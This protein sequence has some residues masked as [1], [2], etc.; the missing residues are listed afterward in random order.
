[1]PPARSANGQTHRPTDESISSDIP[2]DTTA[3]GPASLYPKTRIPSLNP[4]R[5]QR[6]SGNRGFDIPPRKGLFLRRRHRI[7]DQR[8]WWDKVRSPDGDTFS[9]SAPACRFV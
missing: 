4:A 3:P 9:R 2:P 7:P 6:L 1:M 5:A 8:W